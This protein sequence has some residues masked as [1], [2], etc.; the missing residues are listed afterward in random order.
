MKYILAAIVAGIVAGV[1]NAAIMQHPEVLNQAYSL[2]TLPSCNA[3]F[4]AAAAAFASG[5]GH[6][7]DSYVRQQAESVGCRL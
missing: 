3:Q 5:T 1:T 2:V 7:T 4:R 6:L